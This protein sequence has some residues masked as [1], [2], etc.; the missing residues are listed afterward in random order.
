MCTVALLTSLV[1]CCT[2][3]NWDEWQRPTDD[4]H[5]AEYT[6]QQAEDYAPHCDDP[7]FIVC[8]AFTLAINESVDHGIPR[9]FTQN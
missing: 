8:T 2:E 4:Q 7:D 1:Y 9:T 3:E 5:E 6:E